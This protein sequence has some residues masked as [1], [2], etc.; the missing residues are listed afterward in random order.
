MA[1]LFPR[2]TKLPMTVWVSLRGS[3]TP[4]IGGG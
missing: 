3:L 2:T 4:K 1:S